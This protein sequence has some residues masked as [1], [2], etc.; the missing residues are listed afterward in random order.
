VQLLLQIIVD[1][2]L[3]AAGVLGVTI[4]LLATPLAEKKSNDG[5]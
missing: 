3:L 5:M 4:F 2:A 1:G